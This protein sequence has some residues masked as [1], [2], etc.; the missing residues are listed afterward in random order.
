MSSTLTASLTLPTAM[1]LTYLKGKKKSHLNIFFTTLQ[2]PLNLK[3]GKREAST[4][5]LLSYRLV[6]Q[7]DRASSSAKILPSE[8]EGGDFRVI[9]K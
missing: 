4:P 9:I 1:S 8:G 2:R 3:E 7:W 5:N 6:C